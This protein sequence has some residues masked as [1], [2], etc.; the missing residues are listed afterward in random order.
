MVIV[1]SVHVTCPMTPFPGGTTTGRLI[2]FA[3]ELVVVSFNSHARVNSVDASTDPSPAVR[4][5]AQ[6]ED[7]FANALNSSL[8]K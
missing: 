1:V 3:S 8:Q 2:V 6:A 7:E 4:V 5:L